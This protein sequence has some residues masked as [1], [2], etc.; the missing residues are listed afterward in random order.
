M[1]EKKDSKDQEE[2]AENLNF[3]FQDILGDDEVNS[4]NHSFQSIVQTFRNED[5]QSAS[6]NNLPAELQH[7][8]SLPESNASSDIQLWNTSNDAVSSPHSAVSTPVHG[9]STFVTPSPIP[10]NSPALSKTPISQTSPPPVVSPQVDSP[11]I[12]IEPQPQASP[13]PLSPQISTPSNASPQVSLPPS[14]LVHVQSSPNVSSPQVMSAQ[15]SPMT[16][17]PQIAIAAATTTAKSSPA[18]SQS[19]KVIAPQHIQPMIQQQLQPQPPITPQSAPSP[20]PTP[21]TATTPVATGGAATSMTLLDNLTA[22]LSPDRKDRFIELFRQLQNNDVTANQFLAQA[23]MLLDQQ[24]YQQLENLKSKPT[25]PIR[26]P[27]QPQN[28]LKRP[29]NSSQAE[30]SNSITQDFMNTNMLKELISTTTSAHD[31][32]IGPDVVTLIA[33]ATQ[34]RMKTIIKHMIIA[35]KHRVD[36]QTF[37]QPTPDDKGNQPFKIVDVQDIKKQLLAIERVER[38]EERKRKEVISERERKAQLG[39]ETNDGGDEDKPSKKKKKKDMGPGVT[40]RYMSDDV[41]N[42]TTNETALMIAGGVMKSWMLTGMS[43]SANKEKPPPLPVVRQPSSQEASTPLPPLPSLQPSPAT[44]TTATTSITPINTT[45][46]P[47]PLATS[48]TSLTFGGDPTTPNDDQPRG[49]GR[50]RRRKSNTGWGIV[51]TSL[52]D[53]SSSPIRRTR[54]QKNNSERCLICAGRRG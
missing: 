11:Q 52:Y 19:P 15:Q 37:T 39:E 38:E 22:Q 43:P 45:L 42:K 20:A 10:D 53:R 48:P 17:S 40:A 49:R 9:P 1:S 25:T 33:L 5:N 29:M 41:R 3:S 32:K 23:R 30:D 28:K 13:Q 2:K 46:D 50:P 14:P 8:F 26:P 27:I 36:S 31:L 4:N 35:S 6:Y 21:A 18:P 7:L 16:Q 24:Q 12:A 44:A 54:C 47:S 34:D 51:F